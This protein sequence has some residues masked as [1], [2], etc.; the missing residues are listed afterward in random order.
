MGVNK[1]KEGFKVGVA[2]NHYQSKSC[3]MVEI[4][5]PK[6]SGSKARE[7]G[8]FSTPTTLQANVTPDVNDF[9]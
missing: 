8:L 5:Q 6:A 9:C 3:F 2:D 4:R 1:M 7:G